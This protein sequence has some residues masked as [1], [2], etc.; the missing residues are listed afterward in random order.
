M[1]DTLDTQMDGCRDLID[2]V[3]NLIAHR[4][5]QSMQALTVVSVLFLPLT[6]IAG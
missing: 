1:L 6:F 2:L 5:N 4:T 3:F